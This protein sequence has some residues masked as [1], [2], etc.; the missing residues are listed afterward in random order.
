MACGLLPNANVAKLKFWPVASQTVING[1]PPQVTV[2]NWNP[3]GSVFA[4]AT[5]VA[6][7]GPLFVTVNVYVMLP[8][9]LMVLLVWVATTARSEL[10]W[11]VVVTELVLFAELLSKKVDELMFPLSVT[12]VFGEFAPNARF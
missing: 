10:R 8:L 12:D 2:P 7:F 6:S 1:A 11:T 9:R 5:L 4:S 3:A